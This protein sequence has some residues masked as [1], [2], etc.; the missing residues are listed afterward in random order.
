MQ[1]VNLGFLTVGKRRRCLMT[2]I[3]FYVEN[4]EERHFWSQGGHEVVPAPAGTT[5]TH[6]GISLN[7]FKPMPPCA[8]DSPGSTTRLTI[9]EETMLSGFEHCH[10]VALHF[11]WASAVG[12][13]KARGELELSL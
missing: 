6:L 3:R 1:N 10:E 9:D 2:S 13:G 7:K 12:C 8:K 4:W 5:L 11:F